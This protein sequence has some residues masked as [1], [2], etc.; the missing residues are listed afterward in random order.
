MSNVVFILGAGCSKSCGAPLMADFLDVASHLYNTAEPNDKSEFFE[1]VFRA[2][3]SL[4][5][6]HSKSQLDINNI[7]SVF[8]AFEIADTIDKL[9]GFE[10][11]EIPK[12]VSALKK[13]IVDTLE[14][15]ISF[16]ISNGH[17]L[18]PVAY[19]QFV[20]LLRDIK[21]ECSPRRDVSVLT[22]NYDIVADWALYQAKLGLDYG[23]CD[24]NNK[25]K[26]LC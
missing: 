4:Q 21:Y 5:R 12:V 24:E 13:L 18:T 20:E 15:T 22:F 1:L 19:K 7:E 26:Y 2:I 25:K 6:V 11:S 3:G 16:P 10:S 14:K 17:I 23:F 8:T 9:P